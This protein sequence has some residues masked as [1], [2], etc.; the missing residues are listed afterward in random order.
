VRQ[1]SRLPKSQPV[2]WN[3]HAAEDA[4]HRVHVRWTLPREMVE[5]VRERAARTARRSAS[6]LVEEIIRAALR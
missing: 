6:A 4:R 5:A 2:D 3:S 1:K